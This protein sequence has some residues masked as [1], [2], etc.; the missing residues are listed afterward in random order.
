MYFFLRKLFGFCDAALKQKHGW[1]TF[2]VAMFVVGPVVLLIDTVLLP[3]QYCLYRTDDPY[4][5]CRVMPGNK[6]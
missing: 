6:N 3:F 2:P 1:I 5:I 4:V